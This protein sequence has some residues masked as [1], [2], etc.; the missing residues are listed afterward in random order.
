MSESPNRI[1][2][3]TKLYS[4]LAQD[5]GFESLEPAGEVDSVLGFAEVESER[6]LGYGDDRRSLYALE[7][8][9]LVELPEPFDFGDERGGVRE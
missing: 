2:I 9:D 3:P 4:L 8:V 6:P 5:A 7:V 1:P